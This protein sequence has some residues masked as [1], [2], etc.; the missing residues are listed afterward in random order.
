MSD[1]LLTV[2]H[3]S[4]HFPV[5]TG[6]F[7][8]R[9]RGAVRALDD[10]SFT[11]RQGETLGVVGESGCGKSTLA[12]TVLWLEEPTSGTVHLRGKEIDRNDLG[13]LRK[14]MQIVFQDPYT[15]LPPGT[16]A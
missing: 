4:K 6:M 11:L 16:G 10:V 7:S 8:R 5:R 2:E 9:A 13:M 15:S 1:T 12:C 3:L 14:E